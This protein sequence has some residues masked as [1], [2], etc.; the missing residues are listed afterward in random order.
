MTGA[1]GKR[2]T[3]NF[4]SIFYKRGPK[5]SIDNLF[6]DDR[7]LVAYVSKWGKFLVHQS[8]FQHD[9][10]ITDIDKNKS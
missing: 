5:V 10:K 3:N 7:T 6:T 1:I 9:R 8:T 2:Q 4:S